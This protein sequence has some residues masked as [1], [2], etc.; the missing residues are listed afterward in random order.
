MRVP[1]ILASGQPDEYPASEC[2]TVEQAMRA[3]IFFLKL[4]GSQSGSN[5]GK[6]R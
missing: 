6:I 1:F 2:V 5:G 3:L 4:E